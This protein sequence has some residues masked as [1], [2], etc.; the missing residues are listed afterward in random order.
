MTKNIIKFLKTNF[1]CTFI[2]VFLGF[3]VACAILLITGYSPSLSMAVM[4][5]AVFSRAKFIVNVIIK[6]TPIILTGLSVT[7]AFKSGLFNMG[8]EGQFIVSTIVAAI[9][10]I[11]CNFHPFI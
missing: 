1:M 10:G 2:A 8:A 6:S 11:K 9:L 7:L 5:N 3:M 4:F